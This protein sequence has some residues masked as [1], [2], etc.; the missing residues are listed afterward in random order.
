MEQIVQGLI[1]QLGLEGCQD[2][3]VGALGEKGLS[4]GERKRTSIGVELVH[5]PSLVFLD[6][7]TTGLDSS[8]AL[9]MVLLLKS[10]AEDGRSIILTLHQPSSMI[11]KQLDRLLLLVDGRLVYQGQPANT[12]SYFMRQGYSCPPS[13]NVAE[14][15][16]GVFSREGVTC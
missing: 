8:I 2:V 9:Q 10:L 6:E 12:A 4:G 15:L 14:Y 16:M 11:F 5:N 13:M 7:P 1:V 3:R